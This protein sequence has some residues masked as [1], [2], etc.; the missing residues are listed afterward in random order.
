MLLLLAFGHR[1]AYPFFPGDK[2]KVK[3]SVTNMAL[4]MGSTY[5]VLEEG[6]SIL[7]QAKDMTVENPDI[8]DYAYWHS[9]MEERIESCSFYAGM[10]EEAAVSR[11]LPLAEEFE[12]RCR[13]G[14]SQRIVYI[15]ERV[16]QSVKL[17]SGMFI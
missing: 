16:L 15:S 14:S 12:N 4:V 2:A 3:E 5:Y 1:P 13:Q 6:D 11:Y 8:L 9:Q 10:Y 17:L 7:E